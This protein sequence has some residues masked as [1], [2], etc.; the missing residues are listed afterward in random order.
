MKGME[1]AVAYDANEAMEIAKSFQPDHILMDLG[2]SVM[3]F[4]L[5]PCLFPVLVILNKNADY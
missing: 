1:T 2:K 4:L 3:K 5:L